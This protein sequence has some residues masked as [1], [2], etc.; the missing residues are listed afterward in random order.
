MWCLS[1]HLQFHKTCWKGF[2]FS[3]KNSFEVLLIKVYFYSVQPYFTMVVQNK[4]ICTMHYVF[5]CIYILTSFSWSW[6]RYLCP[7]LT[8]LRSSCALILQA[9]KKPEVSLFVLCLSSTRSFVILLPIIWFCQIRC[10]CQTCYVWA[11]SA[12]CLQMLS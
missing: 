10:C 2:C 7:W 9:T 1:S 3:N 5:I 4:S 6:K 11:A 12:I 8:L